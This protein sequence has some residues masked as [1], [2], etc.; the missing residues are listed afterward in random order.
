MSCPH[1]VDRD[2]L[3]IP[4]LRVTI[5]LYV[6]VYDL[7]VVLCAVAPGALVFNLHHSSSGTQ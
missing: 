4:H 7:N 2:Y 3:L 6:I 1:C 5:Q